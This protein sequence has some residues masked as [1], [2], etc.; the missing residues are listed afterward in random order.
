MAGRHS[1]A[2]EQ[3]TTAIRHREGVIVVTGEAGT[4][5]TALCRALQETFDP[6]IFQS[7]ILDPLSSDEDLLYR[8]LF[9]FGLITD[10]NRAR[11]QP[12]TDATRQTLVA[13]LQTFLRSLA[14]LD[15]HAVIVINNAQRLAPR[16]FEALRLLSSVDIDQAKL[17]QIVLVGQP[18]FD[19][20]LQQPD[21][22][23][24]TERVARHITLRMPEPDRHEP[25]PHNNV[26]KLYATAALLTLVAV[27]GTW[28][29]LQ[30]PGAPEAQSPHVSQPAPAPAT[31]SAPD[32]SP[33]TPIE[34]A[35]TA[36]ATIAP[37]PPTATTDNYQVVVASF[38]TEQRATE[39]VS[40]IEKLGHPASFRFD[41][42]GWYGVM[43]GPFE[44]RDAARAAQDDLAR[45][46]FAGTRVAQSPPAP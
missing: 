17:L 26:W 3:V 6:R 23:A 15:A 13:T 24:F 9:D 28:W 35:H 5:K 38:R 4:G 42:T 45:A 40:Q 11:R 12:F 8:V 19:T 31:T 14:S 34:P 21:L 30:S 20:R 43:A 41:S 33:A 18:D 25:A 37:P 10:P 44:T 22:H 27:T 7:V 46:G 39:V 32:E 36:P 16:I 1:R 2:F 29:W